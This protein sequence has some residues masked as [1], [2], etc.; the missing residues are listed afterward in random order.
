MITSRQVRRTAAYKQL[1]AAKVRDKKRL[2]V[3]L[4]AA[5]NAEGGS[6]EYYCAHRK[7]ALISSIKW[8][9]TPQGHEFWSRINEMISK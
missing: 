2:I 9:Y 6:L 4:K 8:V 5:M 3:S 1:V 7:D